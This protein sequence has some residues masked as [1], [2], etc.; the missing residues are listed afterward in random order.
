[1]SICAACEFPTDPGVVCN[2]GR[3]FCNYCMDGHAADCTD[4]VIVTESGFVLRDYQSLAVSRVFAE[5]LG[6]G[7]DSEQ[8]EA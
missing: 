2:C 3:T 4:K 5:L 7:C 8:Y 6:D 1:M